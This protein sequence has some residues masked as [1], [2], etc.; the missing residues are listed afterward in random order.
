MVYVFDLIMIFKSGMEDMLEQSIVYCPRRDLVA[1][2]DLAIWDMEDVG[3]TR[4][5]VPESIMALVG[6]DDVNASEVD[7]DRDMESTS[8]C[9]YVAC[10]IIIMK[11]NVMK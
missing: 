9:Q 5:D 1:P 8:I 10:A 2:M 7:G 11:I 3:P 6:P 4:R